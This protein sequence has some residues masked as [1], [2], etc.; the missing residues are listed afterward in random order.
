[1]IDESKIIFY[2]GAPG[3]KW[4]ATAH[5]ISFNEKYPINKSDYNDDR[6]YFHDDVGVAHH[7]AYWGPGN[8]FGENFHQLHT[9][10][11]NE[12]INEIEKP[13]DDKNWEQYRLIKCHH[14]SSQLDYIKETFPTSKI[15][16]VLRPDIQCYRGWLGAGGFDKISYPDYKAFYK[17]RETMEELLVEENTAAK[18]F[19]HDNDLDI[20]VIREKYWRDFWGIERNTDEIDTY[21]RS[22]EM[23]QTRGKAR[24]NYDALIA[25]YNFED[26]K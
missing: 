7:G 11:K 4:S 13:Y 3:S 19:I 5:L 17:N 22:V 25:H 16:I 18:Q 10:S 12:I 26:L 2:T 23:R 20:H 9:M 21:I 15:I 1:M 6:Y 24:L 14:F 8:G